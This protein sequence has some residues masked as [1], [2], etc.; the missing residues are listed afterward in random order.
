MVVA[1]G[2]FLDKLTLFTVRGEEWKKPCLTLL[3]F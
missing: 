1:S 3:S 2:V